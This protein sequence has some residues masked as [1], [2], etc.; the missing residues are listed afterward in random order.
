MGIVFSDCTSLLLVLSYRAVGNNE[1]KNVLGKYFIIAKIM[2]IIG[3]PLMAERGTVP[4]ILSVNL[5]NTLVMI[6]KFFSVSSML[7]TMDVLS[8]RP[9]RLVRAVTIFSVLLFNVVEFIYP[10]ASLRVAVASF[11]M[12]FIALVPA[13]RMITAKR[14]DNFHRM[15]GVIYVVASLPFVP[16]GVLAALNVE[17]NLFTT[18]AVQSLTFVGLITISVITTPSLLLFMREKR[19]EHVESLASTDCLTHLLN[20]HGFVEM[21]GRM[22]S[23]HQIDETMFAVILFDLDHFKR[24][25]DTYGHSFGDVVLERFAEIVQNNLR[26]EDLGCRYGGE[27]FVVCI[28]SQ[29][30]LSPQAIA[31][32]IMKELEESTFEQCPELTITTSVG[33]AK[34]IPGKEETLLSYI[35]RADAALYRAKNAG[36]NCI[37]EDCSEEVEG[38][39]A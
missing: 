31:K 6:G 13:L 24:V 32:R 22:F 34:G 16:R 8:K 27:E 7:Y 33:I 28:T 30:M 9:Y 10:S 15:I 26:T 12:F 11:C 23:R 3:W 5:G 19:D 37:V 2:L 35:E 39:Y 21:G 36:R 29:D 17:Q 4:D 38:M 14:K 1:L 25:N 20:R 18:S